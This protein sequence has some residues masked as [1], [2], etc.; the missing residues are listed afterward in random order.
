[1]AAGAVRGAK[2]MVATDE[3]WVE[4]G[5][6][7]FEARRERGGRRRCGG[8]CARGGGAGG[9]DIGGGGFMLLRLAMG[10]R[11]FWTTVKWR[12]ARRRGT[13]TSSRMERLDERASVIG[14][15]SVAVPGTVAGLELALK[16]FGTMKLAEAM[17]RRFAWRKTGLRE[18]K[19]RPAVA[20]REGG[21]GAIS[22][23]PADFFERWKMW[24]AGDT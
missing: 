14:Y 3:E 6:G 23:E 2:A 12:R 21:I 7:D 20:R 4:S 15:K 22:R 13:C 19:A 5:R 1:M 11:L 10:G 16:T 8:L 24:K 17:G 9:G 18:R